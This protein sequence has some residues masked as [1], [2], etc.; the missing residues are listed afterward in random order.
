MDTEQTP[1]F[2]KPGELMI[3]CPGAC[4]QGFGTFIS[5]RPTVRGQYHT[6]N[7]SPAVGRS[8]ST[9]RLLLCCTVAPDVTHLEFPSG[10][11]FLQTFHRLLSVHH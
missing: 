10:V 3:R 7:F 9:R 5:F 1:L 4:D 8:R 6:L 11:E 2:K